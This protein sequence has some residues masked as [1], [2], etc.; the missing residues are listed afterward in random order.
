[1]DY[2]TLDALVLGTLSGSVAAVTAVT[3]VTKRFADF[4][5]KWIALAVSSAISMLLLSMS[6]DFTAA[7]IILSIINTFVVT[8]L[9]IGVFEGCVKTPVKMIQN[10]LHKKD[11]EDGGI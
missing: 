6:E 11:K 2:I 1:M 10:F 5:P 8:G 9:S 7:G 4:D 3:Q